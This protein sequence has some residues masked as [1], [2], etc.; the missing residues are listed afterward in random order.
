MIK[1]FKRKCQTAQ[2][3]ILPSAI[4]L[5]ISRG[6][7]ET[8]PRGQIATVIHEKNVLAIGVGSKRHVDGSFHMLRKLSNFSMHALFVLTSCEE[9]HCA[10]VGQRETKVSFLAVTLHRIGL[11]TMHAYKI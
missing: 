7:H 10:K 6:R 11:T 1:S 5:E 9:L 3:A 4:F 2:C 8:W